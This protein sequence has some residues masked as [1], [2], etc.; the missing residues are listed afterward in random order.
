M[1]AVKFLHGYIT[2]DGKRTRNKK[3]ALTFEVKR[4]AE[5]F[6]NR[7]GGRVKKIEE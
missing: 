1:Y 4:E 5:L 3:I 2:K 6:A 7:I